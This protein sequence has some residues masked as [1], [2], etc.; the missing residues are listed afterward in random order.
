MAS[1]DNGRNPLRWDCEKQG[2]FNKKRRP[3]IEVFHDVFPRRINFGD[4]DGIVEINGKAL[5]LEWKS[6][7]G[8]IPTGQRIMYSRITKSGLITVICVTG[9]AETM[10]CTSYRL[11]F[12]GE[13]H[14]A[15]KANLDAV[16]DVMRRWVK[17]AEG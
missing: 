15:Q 2:C 1:S 9:N 16:K 6:Y 17:H 4:V 10:E 12:K 13:L 11:F 5:M 3:K 7:E 14:P 8:D